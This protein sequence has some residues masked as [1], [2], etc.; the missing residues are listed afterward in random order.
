M[1]H[2]TVSVDVHLAATRWLIGI[3]DT[4]ADFLAGLCFQARG[5]KPQP[6]AHTIEPVESTWKLKANVTGSEHSHLI[7]TRC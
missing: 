3:S 6:E 2:T 5:A 7:V 1:I 4:A